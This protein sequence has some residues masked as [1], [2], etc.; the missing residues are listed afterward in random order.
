MNKVEFAAR[1]GIPWL[2]LVALMTFATLG[3]GL[4]LRA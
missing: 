2:A 4:A 1:V 3:T